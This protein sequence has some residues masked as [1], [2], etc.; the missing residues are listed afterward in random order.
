MK[1][2]FSLIAAATLLCAGSAMAFTDKPIKL[3][4]PA[5]PGGTIDVFARIIS[6]QLAQEIQQPVIV[7]NKPG[8][9]GAVAIKYMLS[10]PAD[11]QVLLVSVTNVLTESPHVL[12]GGFDPLKDV[13]P[14]AEMA[15]SY[16]VFIAAPQFPA[17]DAK[18][19]IAFA[20][21]AHETW[22]RKPSNLP[23]ATGAK[24]AV[25]LGNITP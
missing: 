19:A 25:V 4:V 11:G 6:D 7:E 5:P 17:N 15:R 2:R 12:A 23:S 24:R 18:E 13:T 3:V 22:R 1:Y 20:V 10:Q 8:A 9:G 16:L 21:L 14:I